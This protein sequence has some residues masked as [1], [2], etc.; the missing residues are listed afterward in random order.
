MLR[1]ARSRPDPGVRWAAV[2]RSV[3]LLVG[4]VALTMLAC[5][6]AGLALGSLEGAGHMA[7]SAGITALAAGLCL[8][9]GRGAEERD[10][11]RREALVI[12]TLCWV[13]LALFGG[14]PF[15]VG[16]AFTLPDAI[17]ESISGFTTTGAS[18][19]PEIHARLNP[20][21][22]LWRAF[23]HWLGGVGVVV[24]FVA[25]FPAL[26]VGGKLLFHG[27]APG[28]KSKGIT[29]RIRETSL[30]LWKVYTAL[31][32]VQVLLLMGL[33]GLGAFEAT[34]HAFSTMGT[35]G[36]SNRNA[37][38]GEFTQVAGVNAAAVDWIITLFMIIAGMNFGLFYA[39]VRRGPRVILQDAEA[40]AFLWIVG[41][42]TALVTLSILPMKGGDLL[43]ALRH[44][45]FQVASIL[46]TTG[47]AT[48]DFERWPAVGQLVLVVLYFI[49]GCAGSTAGGPKV[50]RVVMLVQTIL[51]ELR[52]SY[53]PHLVAPVRVGDAAFSPGALVEVL[54]LFGLYL[55]TVLAGAF[56]VALF[57]Q[58]DAVTAL[59]ASLACVANVGPAFGDVGPY[60]NYGHF[61]DASKLTLSV[62]MMLGRLEFITVLAL[63]TP[64]FRRR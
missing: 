14:V 51:S 12:V 46:S 20:A 1:D 53:R 16:A 25:V 52:R 15:L 22:H 8:W 4:L 38:V 5:A 26:G 60:D 21:L 3:G 7:I 27:E 58:E 62:C 54:A 61:S 47:F 2:A 6:P 11:G 35:G 31:T 42:A 24:L 19:L 23:T 32:V 63:L 57:D 28:P 13:A 33:G 56:L 18:I 43:L 49:G 39:A 17:F 30:G 55:G 9:V 40:R 64:D 45:A 50:I 29:P 59:T 10:L 44:G 34:V 48:D 37:S 36:F 41:V